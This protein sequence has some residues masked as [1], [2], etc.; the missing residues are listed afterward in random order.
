MQANKK[1]KP[2][3]KPR[4]AKDPR[5]K[6]RLFWWWAMSEIKKQIKKDKKA[7]MNGVKGLGGQGKQNTLIELH[8]S[9]DENE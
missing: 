7:R 9:E 4:D 6:A 5:E 2:K 8:D 1:L 3:K